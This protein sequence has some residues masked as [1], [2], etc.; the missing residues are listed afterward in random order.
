MEIHFIKF[1]TRYSV[2]SCKLCR[3][4]AWVESN[5]HFILSEKR[6]QCLIERRRKNWSRTVHFLAWYGWVWHAEK[7]C[8]CALLKNGSFFRRAL[9]LSPA[10]FDCTRFF[11]VG[12]TINTN[13]LNNYEFFKWKKNKVRDVMGLF[14]S[15][16]F[17][18]TNG[19]LYSVY[20][21]MY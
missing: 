3:H 18:H 20:K 11:W 8:V 9:S 6:L 1:S 14:F 5:F 13:K 17:L 4:H 10:R 15:L 2:C 19:D 7:I 16:L 12:K 21:R